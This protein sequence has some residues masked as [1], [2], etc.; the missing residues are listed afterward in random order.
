MSIRTVTQASVLNDIQKI[1]EKV[2]LKHSPYLFSKN[3]QTRTFLTA[4]DL[5]KES[6]CL[7]SLSVYIA[8]EINGAKQR[9]DRNDYVNISK[10]QWVGILISFVSTRVVETQ[11]QEAVI[12][13]VMEALADY[14]IKRQF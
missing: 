14:L 7:A 11:E 12:L 4:C 2:D 5:L 8:G 10:H 3:G 13:P 6:G 9:T 1:C